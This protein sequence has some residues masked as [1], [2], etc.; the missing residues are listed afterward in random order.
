MLA[1][2]AMFAAAA[3]VAVSSAACGGVAFAAICPDVSTGSTTPCGANDP[4]IDVVID[5]FP[6]TAIYNL[7]NNSV[8]LREIHGRPGETPVNIID[9]APTTTIYNW[10]ENTVNVHI[11]GPA[12]TSI[13]GSIDSGPTTTMFDAVDNGISFSNLTDVPTTSTITEVESS[14]TTN[15]YD[16]VDNGVNI[17]TGLL[18]ASSSSQGAVLLTPTSQTIVIDNEPV[19][20]LVNGVDNSVT[21]AET[22]STLSGSLTT[23][24]D[25]R[26]TTDIV[27]VV[28]NTV[29]LW[30]ND[31][32]GIPI[33]L[34]IDSM[35][36]TL[37]E[38]WVDNSVNVIVVPEPSSWSLLALGFCA[39]GLLRRATTRP[40]RAPRTPFYVGQDGGQT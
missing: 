10:V 18:G 17:T 11:N 20:E 30:L 37:M 39:F 25:S 36:I 21:V 32:L 3:A 16:V 23:V 28:N 5:S 2:H 7:V 38:D 12:G 19:T 27:N 33:A 8:T 26:P 4:A 34:F 6:K 15:I 40:A 13:S 1:K 24:V 14:P 29:D 35:P 22:I 9:S 31:P